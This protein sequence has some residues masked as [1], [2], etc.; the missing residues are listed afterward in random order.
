MVNIPIIFIYTLVCASFSTVLPTSCNDI[1][2]LFIIIHKTLSL[3]AA[4]YQ[5][6]DMYGVE[7][8][9]HKE[10]RRCGPGQWQWTAV[11]Q[12]YIYK[13]K[14]ITRDLVLRAER[15]GYKALVV[16]VNKPIMGKRIAD[17]K[18]PVYLPHHLSWSNLTS[19]SLAE[20]L[21]SGEDSGMT[22]NTKEFND[23]SLTWEAIDW[24]RAV[25]KL[26]IVLKGI[27]TAEDAEE[28]L[29]YKES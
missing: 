5:D 23:P 20:S 9:V 28:V 18:D 15:A 29:K 27:L 22:Q 4:I 17:C 2:Q 13:D 25:T 21:D 11:V 16:T 8:M 19:T 6:G 26:P 24:L 7:Y 14:Q 1:C 10:H 12:L 3:K